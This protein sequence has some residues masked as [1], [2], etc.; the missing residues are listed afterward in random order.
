M[1]AGLARSELQT[2]YKAG[3][4]KMREHTLV[5]G[6]QVIALDS[7]GSIRFFESAR[8]WWLAFVGLLATGGGASQVPLYGPL[9]WAGVGLGIVLVLI[10]MLVPIERGLLIGTSDGRTAM[11]VSKDAAFLRRLLDL[12]T[13]K[14]NSRN[15]A[16]IASFD[17]SSSTIHAYEHSPVLASPPLQRAPVAAV[18]ARD[19]NIAVA[20]NDPAATSIAGDP[21]ID[22]ALFASEPAPT[23]KP[24]LVPERAAAASSERMAPHDPMLDGP[25]I[26]PPRSQGDWLNAPDGL[27]Y[28]GDPNT[29]AGPMRW[30]LPVL[31][32][33]IVAGG[34]VAAW[35]VLR[36]PDGA[37]S[38]SLMT[39]TATS[40]A[41]SITL[42]DALAE[43]AAPTLS[44]A[45]AEPAAALDPAAFTPPEPIVARAS[46]QRYRAQPSSTDDVPVLAE[47]RFGGEALLI[48][49]HVFQ[50][51]G[52]WYRVSLPDGRAAW[53]KA[54]LAIPQVRFAETLAASSVAPAFFVESSPRILEPVEGA[55][56]AGGQ[57]SIRLA[58]TGND[59]ATSYLVEI[60]PFDSAIQRW[61][62]DPPRRMMIP[63]ATEVAETFAVGVWRWRVR[64]VSVDGEQSQL[65]R[66]SAFGVRD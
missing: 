11:I 65:S 55:Q 53:F 33:A 37:M 13:E 49:G 42:A 48:N 41:E 36:N 62:S 56:L 32:L 54:S 31:F 9:A 27:P 18:L 24:P 28:E 17:I 40:P 47:T 30:M 43:T 64:G 2:L 21:D 52:E 16:L 14:I 12:L 57:Q 46:G 44:K 4:G 1:V 6:A 7:I 66:W 3:V 20:S 23:R 10:N 50:S 45:P 34:A 58:W 29:R 60:Q 22:E 51:D 26:A 25:S 39:P 15:D 35:M 63:A 5:L 19:T 61:A 59:S 8:S 38:I